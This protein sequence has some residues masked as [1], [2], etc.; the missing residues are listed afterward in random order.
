M[1]RILVL[2]VMLLTAP[3]FAQVNIGSGTQSTSDA[4]AKSQQ[5]QGLTNA[6][7][8][9][10]E[11]S[12]IPTYTEQ[13]IRNTPSIAL[14]NIYPT[15]PCMGSSS[16]GGSGPGFSVGIGTSWKDDDCGK[17]ETA[18]AF[19]GMNMRD[20]AIA[21]LCASSYADAAPA[22]KAL[23]AKPAP[24]KAA[25]VDKRKTDA[26]VKSDRVTTVAIQTPKNC[27]ADEYIARRQGS[28]VCK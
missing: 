18:R 6:P 3:A 23:A 20:D 15:S 16:V 1:K 14:P 26:T 24:A 12:E 21:V 4:L 25:E 10:N 2:A 13:K 28:P 27:V 8:M 19:A 11:A 17:R 22:C 5:Q 9:V 7:V